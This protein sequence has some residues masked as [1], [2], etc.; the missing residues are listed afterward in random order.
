[1]KRYEH[2]YD[3]V[4]MISPVRN[5]EM[6]SRW[7]RAGYFVSVAYPGYPIKIHFYL[8]RKEECKDD[9]SR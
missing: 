1:M 9:G 3:E 2:M 5:D 4:M 6:V 8:T 7:A